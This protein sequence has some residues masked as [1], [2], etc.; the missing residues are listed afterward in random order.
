MNIGRVYKIIKDEGVRTFC[1]LLKEKADGAKSDEV[2][3]KE[4]IE[5]DEPRINE[6]YLYEGKE[7]QIDIL[8]WDESSTVESIR[9][10]V[11]QC[12]A[13]YIGF[14][15]AELELV[16][17]A[18]TM[19][20][21]YIA[22]V[23]NRNVPDVIYGNED[24]ISH[25]TGVRKN[26]VFK[27][28]YSPETLWSY[29]YI[30]DFACIRKECV[31]RCLKELEQLKESEC[32]GEILY[33]MLLIL[34]LQ[35]DVSFHVM[36]T[37][38][39]HRVEEKQSNI[40]KG[41]QRKEIKSRILEAHG[42]EAEVKN[43]ENVQY[44]DYAYRNKLISIIIPS[45]DN[46]ALLG[47]CLDS[48]KANTSHASYEIIVVDNGSNKEHEIQYR[49]QLSTFGSNTQYIYEKM[50]FN[51][52]KMC[53]IG[54]A[55]A[56]GEILLFLNDDIEILPQNNC[57][58][59]CRDWLEIMAGQAIQKK[60]GA[61]GVKLMY[62]GNSKIQHIGVV[63]Y[64]NGGL[65]HI[66]ARHEDQVPVK[67]YR[68][69]AVY[70]Y[71]C[72]TGACIMVEKEK[73]HQINGFDEDF[74]ITHND[75]DLCI[76]LYEKG[77]YQVQRNDI[78]LIHHESFSR[79]DDGVDEVKDRRNMRER[80]LLYSKHP[81][82]ERYDPFYSICLSQKEDQCQINT[83]MY[84]HVFSD[85]V[86]LE[87]NQINRIKEEKDLNNVITEIT[88]VEYREDLWMRGYAYGDKGQEKDCTNPE[89]ILYNDKNAYLIECKS[90]CDR[91]F[92]KR[93][94]ISYHINFAP[95]FTRINTQNIPKGDYLYCLYKKGKLH[96]EMG[97]LQIK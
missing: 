72:V 44:I 45:K 28:E 22:K 81:Q 83:E 82:F 31:E 66:Y 93:K 6:K 56:T 97:K 58:D 67:D 38:L 7:Q 40:H 54:A 33:V 92:H 95:F 62:P 34:S 13:S 30:G 36:N 50:D 25:K 91:V 47:K 61:V 4:Y 32:G 52:S 42:I 14:K 59:L 57:T 15:H 90:I 51:F 71:L 8:F 53:N 88:L 78:K 76:K 23:K 12:K 26:P 18:V 70:N 49:Q 11:S 3:Y 1:Y 9:E 85:P 5:N 43:Y 63:N 16:H 27:P 46:P 24:E 64:E 55:H 77:F 17:D 89:I 19:I 86:L 75:V 74:A 69:I 68:N 21:A 94:D 29:N 39:S 87:Q 48:I 80:E 65:A 2:R 84:M 79:G 37:V 35:E 10:A 41:N 73:F 96:R 60:T 20:N